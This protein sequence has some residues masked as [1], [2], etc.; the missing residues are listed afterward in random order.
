MS[1]AVFVTLRYGYY[2]NTRMVLGPGSSRL[3]K[4]SS[5]FVKQVEVRA[6]DKKEVLLYGYAEKPELSHE[7]NW[8]VS[9]Y[10]IVG[11]YSRKVS[12]TFL[13]LEKCTIRR[14]KI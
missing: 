3:I 13:C 10:V 1:S 12:E 11:S 7:L 5:I 2:G 9:D 4:A 8:S 14:A 6:D